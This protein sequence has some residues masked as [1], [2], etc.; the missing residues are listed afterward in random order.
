MGINEF[1]RPS[2]VMFSSTNSGH[3]PDLVLLNIE[4]AFYLPDYQFC[5]V[6]YEQLKKYR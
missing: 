6:F 2:F 3:I 4:N 1:Y 5:L